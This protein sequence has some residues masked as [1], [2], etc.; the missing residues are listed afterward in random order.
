MSKAIDRRCWVSLL[1]ASGACGHTSS[2]SQS[3]LVVAAIAVPA[4]LAVNAAQTQAARK[5]S[6]RGPSAG[7]LDAMQKRE[8]FA[9]GARSYSLYCTPDGTACV[10][11]TQYGFEH[12]CKSRDCSDGPPASLRS[13]CDE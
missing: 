11:R 6:E 1:L 10:Y 5:A 13:W 2:L 3:N 4:A 9:C 7:L 8:T 12:A